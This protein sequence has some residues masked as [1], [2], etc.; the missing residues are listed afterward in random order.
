LFI[1]LFW[2]R[3]PAVLYGPLPNLPYGPFY[4]L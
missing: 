1:M 4:I 2:A 3:P